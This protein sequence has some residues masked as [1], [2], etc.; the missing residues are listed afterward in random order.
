MSSEFKSV[1][2]EQGGFGL[3]NSLQIQTLPTGGMLENNANLA[4]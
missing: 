2:F 3:E 1:G 4:S